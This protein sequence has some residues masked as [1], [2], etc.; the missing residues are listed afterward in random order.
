MAAD[1]QARLFQPFTQADTS[2]TRRFG[3]TGLGLSI[4]QRLV[5]QMGGQIQVTS[6]PGKGSKFEFTL[7]FEQ[8]QPDQIRPDQ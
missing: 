2:I 3:G 5:Q 1:Q 8:A 7:C 4:S 6:A